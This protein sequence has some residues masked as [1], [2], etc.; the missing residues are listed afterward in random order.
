MRSFEDIAS[1]KFVELSGASVESKLWRYKKN[2]DI[3]F[4]D[5]GDMND[6]DIVFGGPNDLRRLE[7]I[8]R[9]IPY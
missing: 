4:F 7:D 8:E 9:N 6:D 3:E 1:L 2:G 5:E